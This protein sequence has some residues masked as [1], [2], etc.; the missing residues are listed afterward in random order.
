MG[1]NTL[2]IDL[3]SKPLSRW[4]VTPRHVTETRTSLAKAAD[5]LRIE[6][7]GGGGLKKLLAA[8]KLFKRAA[9]YAEGGAAA[10]LLHTA[11]HCRQ[12]YERLKKQNQRAK[13]VK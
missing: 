2:M 8:E 4:K 12:I 11:D 10:Y 5:L 1:Y 13:A 7:E 9:T 6:G 3:V